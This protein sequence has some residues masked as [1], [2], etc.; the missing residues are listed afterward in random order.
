[1]RSAAAVLGFAI[2]WIGSTSASHAESLLTG[3]QLHDS[4]SARSFERLGDRRT[5]ACGLLLVL[6]ALTICSK[7]WA[8][9]SCEASK[10]CM[11]YGVSGAAAAR[12]LAELHYDQA[13]AERTRARATL[14]VREQNA[15]GGGIGAIVCHVDGLRRV[16]TAF[17]VGRFD[18]A[19]T[20][21]H[22]F[23]ADGQLIDDASCFYANAG[24]AGQ[25]RERIAI[26]YIKS[27]WQLDPDS[28]GQP[29]GDLA[30]VRLRSPVRMARRTLSLTRFDYL[31]APAILVGY[32][33]DLDV[34]AVR[35]KV[36][37]QVYPRPGRSCVRFTHDIDARDIAPG[38][39]LIDV[40]DNVVIGI[41]NRLSASSPRRAPCRSGGNAMLVMSEWLEQ[42]LRAEIALGALYNR[43]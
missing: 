30:I 24:P 13:M 3:A 10:T 33:A 8:V 36:R 16:S 4:I 12:H 15:F 31:Q 17:L 37:G 6:A 25:I 23:E 43:E 27:Q 38:A 32:G 21:A 22:V 19:V 35:R 5:T 41:H 1:M 11:R 9:A 26:A 14:T 42:A 2:G 20:V 29:S 7:A 39:P 40:R 18:V 34:N 28:Y